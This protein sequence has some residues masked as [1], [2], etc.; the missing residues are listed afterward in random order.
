MKSSSIRFRGAVSALSSDDRRMLF[1]RSSARDAKVSSIVSRIIDRV[2]SEGDSTLLKLARELDGVDL[3]SL[4]VPREAVLRARSLVDPTTIQAMER[5]ARNIERVHRA[6]LPRSAQLEVE[7]GVT[8]GR[9]PDPFSRVGVYA[10]GGRAAYPSSVL[11]G[12]IPARVAGVKEIVLSRLR[13][14][15]AF[16]RIRFSP[17]QQSPVWTGCSQSAEPAQS[18]RWLS[19]R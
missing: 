3:S 15:A 16:P 11:M 6:W 4:E 14:R 1:D 5:A 18:Q 2:R 13:V 17:Q 9:R 12:A 8:V 10:P 19:E 7:P